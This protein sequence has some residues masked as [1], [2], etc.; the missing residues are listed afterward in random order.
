MNWIT[1]FVRPK[2]QAIVGKKDI[3][4]NLW[5]TCPKCSQM[6]LKRE[7]EQ[8]L[9]VCKNCGHHLRMSSNSRLNMFFG[10]DYKVL[11]TPKIKPDPLN[12]KDVKKYKERLRISQK[13]TNFQDAV[14]VGIGNI[15]E[16][17]VVCAVF[18]FS[19]MGGSMG[20]SVGEA[21]LA[22]ADF[23]CKENLPL[24]VCSSSGGARMQEG[25]L[26]LMQMPRTIIAI[27]SLK[28]KNI[29]FISIL[30]DPTTGGVSASFAMLGD[31]IIAEKGA[32]IGFAGSRVIEETIKEK[33]PKNF[34]KSEYLINKGLIDIVVHRKEL[35]TLVSRLI[36][37]L[38]KNR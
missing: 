20:M 8:N 13:N 24:I 38:C 34:Q 15:E 6:L 18:D 4:D 35:K 21:I 14:K 12:F 33:L 27:N 28:E 3:P 37:L 22:S 31:I 30:T 9:N 36:S 26:S 10:A 32:T 16:N 11:E 25:I 17:K 23:C 2:L 7:L 1:N 19:F 29:P 5:Q